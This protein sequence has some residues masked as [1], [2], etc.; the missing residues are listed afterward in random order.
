[1]MTPEQHKVIIDQWYKK[2]Q[3][4]IKQNPDEK[5]QKY[6]NAVM[7]FLEMPNEQTFQAAQDALPSYEMY[8]FINPS[9]FWAVNAE[10][11]MAS[12]LGSSW[13]RFKMAVRRLFE[14]L[15]HVFGFDNNYPVHKMFKDIMTGSRERI[16]KKMLIDYVTAGSA[17]RLAVQNIEDDRN[18]IEKYNRPNT[19]Q[20]DTT[21]VM[22][23][24]TRQFKNG[25]EFFEDAVEDPKQAMVGAGNAVMDAL[26][27]FR[28]EN[29]WYGAGL[30]ARDFD[31]YNGDLRTSEGIATAS[32]ALDNA[33][34]SGNIATEVLFRGGIKYDRESNNYVAVE[35][36]KGMRGVYE[37]EKKL[38]DKLG[39]QLGTDIIQGYLEAKRSISIMDEVRERETKLEYARAYLSQLKKIGADPDEI[40]AAEVAKEAAAE[41]VNGIRNAQSSVLMS[42]EEM[43]EFAELEN[44][45][46]ELRDILDNFTAV[47]QNLLRFWRQVGLLSQARY[48][49][50]A[51]IPDY[52]PWNRIMDDEEDVHS[53]L[54]STTRTLTNIGREK[55]FKRG[56]PISVVDFR[57]REG[58]TDFQIQP[59]SVVRVEVNGERIDPDLVSVTPDG[60]VRLAVELQDNDLVVF[61][62]NREIENIVDNMTR[63]VM[64]MTMN[65]IRQF[66][67]N[68]IVLEYAS[69]DANN[70]IM[71]FPS[72]DK[73]KGRFNWIVNGQ[74]VVVE[75]QD[76]LVAASIYGMENL[77]LQMWKPLAMAANFVRRSITL[78][79]VFQVKQVFKDAPTAALV[80]GVRNPLALIGGVWKGFLTSLTNTDPV[81]DI[82][83]AAGIGGFHSPART[84]EAE[85]KRRLGIMNRNVFSAFIKG[86]D[87]IGD[88]SDMAQRVAV[89]KRV[90]A[91]TGD[92]TQALFQAANVINFLHHGSAGYAQATVKVVPFMGAYANSID[93][94]VRALAGSGLKGMSR[95]KA[96]A[97]LAITGALLSSLMILY[98]MMAG[99]DPD[100]DELDDQTKLKNIIIP[101][102]KIIL[103]MNTSAAF[104][105]KAIPELI[106]NKVTREGTEN[107]MD[108]RRLRKA[109]GEAARDMLLGPEPIPA[110]VKPLLEVAIKHDFFTGRPVVPEGLKDVEAAE[111]YTATTSELGKK[112]SAMLAIPGTDKRVVSPIEADHL[113]R[114]IFGTAG[115]MAQW[116]TN[117]I[118][119]AA[120]TRP[121]L[122][123]REQPITGSFMRD[124]VPRGR[125]DLFYDFKELVFAK[126]KTWKKMVDRED[127]DAAD[128]YLEKHGDVVSMYE[129]INSTENDLKDINVEIRRLGETKAKDMTPKERR[130]EIDELRRIR[131]EILEPVKELRREVVR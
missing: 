91:E 88:S 62:T 8:Q 70:K 103:P 98:A 55:L 81:V 66:A 7:D 39:D 99:A 28:Q 35:T 78:S 63:N 61:Q 115:A 14:G 104:F 126:Y 102:T 105:F 125:E 31:K 12:Q 97:R 50:L 72:V 117:S 56:K 108:R 121:E 82:L 36:K 127:Y 44:K 83:K 43:Y 111:Q 92:K 80:T 10:P 113:V 22:T 64:R 114:G 110:G 109:L 20:L 29:V 89:Y 37:A 106:Y 77:N 87:H 58:Q 49:S 107:E 71:V 6:F 17:T 120:E 40:A 73:E 93:V 130:Q 69:R 76:P 94:L 52:V 38:K 24:V 100:Y 75:I 13:D 54:Q 129:Y 112:I 95:Q 27:R 122:T 11:L 33:I 59:S 1:M 3:K 42:E 16:T 84:P 131:N 25:K 30:E 128:A 4:A 2:L 5:H 23:F 9:E 60:Q 48:E 32:V 118:G 67:S 47:N 101:G 86:L 57:A 65:G 15:K 26:I 21:P 124:E 74:K 68:R 96:L 123:P 46:P 119:V 116:V 53:P 79:G 19:P 41:A 34:R 90:L 45:H 18:L 85:I 51:S